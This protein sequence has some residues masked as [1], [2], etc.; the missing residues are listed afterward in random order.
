MRIRFLGALGALGLAALALGPVAL[1]MSGEARADAGF[2]R[3]V[4]D[5]RSTAL[6]NGVSGATYDRAF[7]G[8]TEP[9][10]SVLRAASHQPE[11]T[12][13]IWDYLDSAV[14]D[15]RLTNGRRMLERYRGVLDVIEARVRTRQTGAVWQRRALE[16]RGDLLAMMA[17]YCEGQRSGAPVHEWAT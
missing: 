6:S 3:W 7:A 1:S 16:K 15:T 12:R 8:V 2:Q 13:A 10:A 5:F 9:D 17:A 11:F 14:S 4:R